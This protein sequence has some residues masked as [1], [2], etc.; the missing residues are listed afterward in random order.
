MIG[1]GER[2]GKRKQAREA[3]ASVARDSLIAGALKELL[4]QLDM[5]R[6]DDDEENVVKLS[7]RQ[8]LEIWSPGTTH[9][10]FPFK[11][12]LKRLKSSLKPP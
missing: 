11:S 1:G 5:L 4:R 6:F 8:D 2:S 10:I 12:S 9:D 7:E 3:R